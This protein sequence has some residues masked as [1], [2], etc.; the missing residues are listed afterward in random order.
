[1]ARRHHYKRRHK[2][3][4][5][6]LDVTTF[7]N[8]MV[9]LV[10]FLLITAVFSRLTIIELNLP[11]TAGGPSTSADS[12]RVEVIVREHG[13]EISNGKEII[14]A[15]PNTDED[16]DLPTLSD[17]MVQL[18]RQYPEHDAVSVLMEAQIPYDYLI[19]VMDIVRSIEVPI[20]SVDEDEQEYELVALFSEISVGDAP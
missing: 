3:A 8:L 17:Y 9:V 18:K 5:H 10:P 14:A 4:A 11:S 1:M 6:E 19:Q 20:E 7:L 12:F 15:I 2:T 13:I 16:F